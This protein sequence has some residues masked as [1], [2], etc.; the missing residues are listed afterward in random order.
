M[1]ASQ[2]GYIKIVRHLLEAPG[3][4]PSV[5]SI[6]KGHTALCYA[7]AHGHQEIVELLLAFHGSGSHNV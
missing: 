7:S 4:D 3:I 6:G 5:T 1:I 2:K